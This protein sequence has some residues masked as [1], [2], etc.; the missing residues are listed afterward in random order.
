[1]IFRQTLRFVD[2]DYSLV[3][4][5][6]DFIIINLLLAGL[7]HSMGEH[8]TLTDISAGILLS[9]L[10][11]LA[12]ELT[13]L[14][15]Q[16]FKRQLK[17]SCWCFFLTAFISYA[18]IAVMIWISDDFGK[19]SQS[20]S[21]QHHLN[22]QV[23]HLWFFSAL[24]LMLTAR[25]GGLFLGRAF[26]ARKRV[27]IVGLTKAGIATKNALL[28]EFGA[29]EIDIKFYDERESLSGLRSNFYGG[30]LTELVAKAKEEQ[31]DHV[32]IALPMIARDRIKYCLDQLSDTMVDTSMVPDLESYHLAVSRVN[33]VRNVQIFSVFSTPFNG[34][35]A[36]VKRLEDLF[37]A[38]LI[39]LMI[40]P[41][42]IVIAVGVKLSSPGPVLFKQDRYGLGGKK[43]KVWKFRSM[44][45]MENE[46]HVR[47]ATK[48]DPRVTK[49]GAFIRRTS[50]D[51]L[52][53]FI[54]VLQGSMSIVGPRPHAVA[55]NEQYRVIIENYMIRHKVKPGITGWAQVNGYRG[56]T[57]TVDKMEKRVQYDIQYMQNWSLWFDLK[58]IFK[59][60]FV[61]FVSEAAY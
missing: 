23:Y 46:S 37:I 7:I 26:K 19:M 8:E 52:P 34:F 4:K 50:L 56:E 54:N 43:I 13:R 31:I 11:I 1:M 55:H 53:Q 57:E 48:H 32:Y 47:Q 41:V 39:I 38:S 2:D 35:K 60:V 5:A 15:S 18:V 9:S 30:S 22:F 61:G 44:R 42:L 16:R 17:K 51:E 21:H 58:I 14:Y 20:D 28:E 59:T 25:L 36:L 10:F 33:T 40:L 24:I 27:A 12:G 3:T 45:V 29:Q 49:F 6:F